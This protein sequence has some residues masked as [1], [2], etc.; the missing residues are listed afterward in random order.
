[1][2]ESMRTTVLVF[3]WVLGVDELGPSIHPAP[4]GNLIHRKLMARQHEDKMSIPKK[5]NAGTSRL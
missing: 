4:L 5:D 3:F 1:M 2:P